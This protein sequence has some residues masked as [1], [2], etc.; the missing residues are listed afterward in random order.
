MEYYI[1]LKYSEGQVNWDHYFEMWH[2][3]DTGEKSKTFIRLHKILA[4]GNNL[5]YWRTMHKNTN[6]YLWWWKTEKFPR[7]IKIKQSNKAH[8]CAL[9]NVAKIILNDDY[10]DFIMT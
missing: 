5:R 4:Q 6:H 2:S 1:V 10:K 7:S 8:I 3:G 9:W